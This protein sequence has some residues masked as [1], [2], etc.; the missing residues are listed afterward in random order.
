MFRGKT[1]ET[2]RK[3]EGDYK[4]EGGVLGSKT[5]KTTSLSCYPLDAPRKKNLLDN[6]LPPAVLSAFQVLNGAPRV[7]HFICK[8]LLTLSISGGTQMFTM[9]SG[10]SFCVFSPSLPYRFLLAF[11]KRFLRLSS[12]APKTLRQ[13]IQGAPQV[14]G[15]YV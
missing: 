2:K 3:K 8:F 4:K 14:L 7:R 5:G 9:G 10:R 12:H 11:L 6:R 15:F 1:R 13:C